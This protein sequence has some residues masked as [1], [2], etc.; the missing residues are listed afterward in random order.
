MERILSERGAS[1][2]QIAGIA[3]PDLPSVAL[4]SSPERQRAKRGRASLKAEF[5]FARKSSPCP[6]VT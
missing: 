6:V 3:Q 1:D 4:V 2:Y 5:E